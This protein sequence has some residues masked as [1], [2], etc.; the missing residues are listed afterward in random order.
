MTEFEKG[1]FS[2]AFIGKL[3]KQG[4]RYKTWKERLFLYSEITLQYYDL[5]MN[6]QGEF[7]CEECNAESMTVT[8]CSA[9]KATYPFMLSN[10]SSGGEFL[11]C[12]T[13]SASFQSLFIYLVI[14]KL[15][16]F[17]AIKSLINIPPMKKG[18]IKKQ[19]HVVKNWKNR[20]FILNYGVLTY[21][22]KDG[23]ES[24]G[25]VEQ[26][27]GK[28]ELQFATVSNVINDEHGKALSDKDFRI[29]VSLEPPTTTSASSAGGNRSSAAVRQS[30]ASS[31]GA[32]GGGSGSK[33]YK[34]ILQISTAEEKKDWFDLIRKH[35]E[36]AKE[37]AAVE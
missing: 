17:H 25:L 34:L 36:Y 33:E 24:S 18:W 32:N 3:F 12:Y 19:G 37:Y 30:S 28:I 35:I 21:Y 15:T 16:H 26:A 7:P 29:C 22:D 4:H 23:G 6:Y 1:D 5:K 2:M 13:D 31:G 20:F 8:Q 11:N 27:K 9:P 10:Y 14:L